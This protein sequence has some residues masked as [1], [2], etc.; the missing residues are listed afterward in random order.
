MSTIPNQ[1]NPVKTENLSDKQRNKPITRSIIR[2]D[3]V[4]DHT[5]YP[6]QTHYTLLSANRR[7]SNREHNI[8]T[9]RIIGEATVTPYS[10]LKRRLSF[11]DFLE[12]LFTIVSSLEDINF[13]EEELTDE[14]I[15]TL[16]EMA[17]E[18]NGE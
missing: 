1:S 3:F 11:D 7:A 2:V 15:N 4:E 14:E 6:G 5:N 8:Y 9:R 13:K 18:F 12:D 10:V 17:G 16:K